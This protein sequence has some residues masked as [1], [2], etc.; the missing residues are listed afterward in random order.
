MRHLLGAG[1][2]SGNSSV[3]ETDA[4][5][6]AGPALVSGVKDMASS[7]GWG[8]VSECV[9]SCVCVCTYTLCVRTRICFQDRGIF[10]LFHTCRSEMVRWA[11]IAEI[12]SGTPF[13][14]YLE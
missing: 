11:A 8:P 6:S 12:M 5:T 10:F 4:N 7:G 3:I 14:N 1:L 9:P 2:A 13:W